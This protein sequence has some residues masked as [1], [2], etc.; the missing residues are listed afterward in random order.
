MFFSSQIE[1]SLLILNRRLFIFYT[2]NS[3]RAHI[4][5]SERQIFLPLPYLR[6][7]A[8]RQKSNSPMVRQRRVES[9]E[10]NIRHM[11]FSHFLFYSVAFTQKSLIPS[12]LNFSFTAFIIARTMLTLLSSTYETR[13]KFVSGHVEFPSL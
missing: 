8:A 10:A 2:L 1:K 11:L 7:R 13:I 5:K 4:S 6:I 12:P 9:N 3:L